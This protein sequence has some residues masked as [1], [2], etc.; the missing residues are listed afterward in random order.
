MEGQ[1]ADLKI[2]LEGSELLPSS[3]VTHIPLVLLL[4]FTIVFNSFCEEFSE[5]F[6]VLPE[7]LSKLRILAVGLPQSKNGFL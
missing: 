5:V 1:Q 2:S 6:M 4:V 3:F 7:E